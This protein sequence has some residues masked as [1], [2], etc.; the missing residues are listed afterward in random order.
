[1]PANAVLSV[2][3]LTTLVHYAVLF[4]ACTLGEPLVVGH[5]DG[6]SIVVVQ[7]AVIRVLKD[8]P[9]AAVRRRVSRTRRLTLLQS[10]VTMARSL[11]RNSSAVAI[12]IGH[13]HDSAPVILSPVP[14]LPEPRMVIRSGA[15]RREMQTTRPGFYF[16]SF[17]AVA[18]TEYALFA[19]TALARA[20]TFLRPLV[21]IRSALLAGAVVGAHRVILPKSVAS[22]RC[23]QFLV[24]HVKFLMPTTTVG[25]VGIHTMLRARF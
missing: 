1:M 10:A 2:L 25:I 13:T 11:F 17:A 4:L 18:D 9:V 15:Q 3:A 7:P 22:E 23:D 8:S 20:C 12:P 21:S 14:V 5:T 6:V 24:T 16:M 19:G